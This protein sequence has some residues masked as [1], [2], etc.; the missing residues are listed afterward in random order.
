MTAATLRAETPYIPP[1]CQDPAAI[2]E[3]MQHQLV[4]QRICEA[5]LSDCCKSAVA[6]P[7]ANW[8]FEQALAR[9]IARKRLTV[10]FIGD[11]VSVGEKDYITTRGWSIPTPMA[12]R[13]WDACL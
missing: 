8:R 7:D 13:C 12:T 5:S 11:S 6:L 9:A 2:S 1:D 4:L 3:V 10:T